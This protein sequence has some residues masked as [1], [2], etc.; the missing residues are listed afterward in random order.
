M[1]HIAFFDLLFTKGQIFWL[2]KFKAFADD[3]IKYVLNF[4]FFFF[5]NRVENIMEI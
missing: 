2:T 3:K 4:Y 5:F 1:L